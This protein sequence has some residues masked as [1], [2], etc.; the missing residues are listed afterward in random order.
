MRISELSVE[1]GEMG[2][3][4]ARLDRGFVRTIVITRT[5]VFKVRSRTPRTFE[6]CGS[7]APRTL[8]KVDKA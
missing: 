3:A 2:R 1:M 6:E 7:T 4:K 5:L 8:K